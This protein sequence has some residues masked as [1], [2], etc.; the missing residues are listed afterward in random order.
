MQ[1]LTVLKRLC[2][3]HFLNTVFCE[4]KAATKKRKEP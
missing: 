4:E 1:I 2:L 3:T